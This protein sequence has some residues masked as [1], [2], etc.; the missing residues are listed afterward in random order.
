MNQAVE[1]YE[2]KITEMTNNHED[3]YNALEEEK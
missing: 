2:D 3:A 1:D